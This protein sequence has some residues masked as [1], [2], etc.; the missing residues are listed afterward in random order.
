MDESCCS[1][2]FLVV[3]GHCIIQVWNFS[4]PLHFRQEQL[5]SLLHREWQQR[6]VSCYKQLCSGQRVVEGG[7]GGDV[8]R[9][10]NREGPDTE[11]AI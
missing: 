3:P 11:S 10:R 2:H 6:A 4:K 8:V 1:V 7:G 9:A 5:Y